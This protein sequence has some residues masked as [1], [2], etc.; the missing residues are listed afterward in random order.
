MCGTFLCIDQAVDGTLLAP[1]NAI[2]VQLADPTKGTMEQVTQLQDYLTTQEEAVLAY[3]KSNMIL[4]VHSNV[5]CLSEPKAK[6]QVRGHFFTSFNSHN[7]PNNGAIFNI[8]H[9]IKNIMSSA[10]DA[11]LPA[12]YIMTRESVYICILLEEMGY[13]QPLPQF[14]WTMQ[15]QIQRLMGKYNQNKLRP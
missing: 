2:A 6:S 15:W 10:T 12:L 9:I 5:S 11:E 4:A 1:I 14:I 8:A 3:I 7:L 13:R